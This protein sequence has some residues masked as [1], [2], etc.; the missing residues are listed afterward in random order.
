MWCKPALLARALNTSAG[1]GHVKK[2]LRIFWA[3]DRATFDAAVQRLP[4]GE[5]AFFPL[6][7]LGLPKAFHNA[8]NLATALAVPKKKNN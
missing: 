3:R 5:R 8:G 6:A 7:A 1:R 4:E 2:A